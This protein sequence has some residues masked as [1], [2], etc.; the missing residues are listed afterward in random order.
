MDIQTES[1]NTTSSA[2]TVDAAPAT[3]LTQDMEADGQH[4]AVLPEAKPLTGLEAV[5]TPQMPEILATANTKA[6]EVAAQKT[7]PQEPGRFHKILGALGLRASVTTE[8][9]TPQPTPDHLTTTPNGTLETPPVANLNG[10]TADGPAVTRDFSTPAA[11]NYAGLSTPDAMAAGAATGVPFQN[12]IPSPENGGMVASTPASA[13]VVATPAPSLG[14]T[15]PEVVPAPVVE[16]AATTLTQDMENAG[17]HPAVLETDAPETPAVFTPSADVAPA[18]EVSALP[19]APAAAIPVEGLGDPSKTAATSVET[20]PVVEP[21]TEEVATEDAPAE[22]L[23]VG[24]SADA[25][26]EAVHA[27]PGAVADGTMAPPD[28]SVDGTASHPDAPVVS[29]DAAVDGDALG[30]AMA[31]GAAVAAERPPFSAAALA[32]PS[33]QTAEVGHDI[34]IETGS[35]TS[36]VGEIA[37]D[38][39]PV[40]N[41]VDNEPTAP[42]VAVPGTMS[43]TNPVLPTPLATEAGIVDDTASLSAGL[44]TTPPTPE[45]SDSVTQFPAQPG[46][47]SATDDLAKA[48]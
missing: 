42:T 43:P 39:A 35:E 28:W 10:A 19:E 23:P 18:E 9:V 8:T 13:E 2:P 6:A 29:G 37:D 47:A 3:T 17:E 26:A 25:N 5:G 41:D 31:D 46:Q 4:P 40:A 32:E 33:D 11:N 48:A 34:P 38:A 44:P 14:T 24:Q 30:Q 12:S 15:Q 27:G 20:T 36:T 45:A 21:G 22:E 16:A 1:P 7:A